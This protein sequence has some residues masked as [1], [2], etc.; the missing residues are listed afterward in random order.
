MFRALRYLHAAGVIHRDM[1][2]TNLLLNRDCEL[3]LAD[4]G[5]ARCVP[6]ASRRVAE[7]RM[8]MHPNS[9]ANLAGMVGDEGRGRAAQLTKYVVTRWYRAPELL[10]QNRQYDAKVDMWSV[11][12]I[13]AELLGAKAIFPGKDSLHQVAPRPD[14]P[15]SLRR[16]H[17]PTC[18][19]PAPLSTSPHSPSTS[20]H[21]PSYPLASPLAPALASTHVSIRPSHE[22]T[23][24]SLPGCVSCD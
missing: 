21:A 6:K 12:C 2:P 14:L 13:L 5:L 4:F 20:S 7:G 3:A 23:V 1:K 19:C 18:R 8:G 9:E 22:L 24:H 15:S 16:A 17:R 11:G 10:V